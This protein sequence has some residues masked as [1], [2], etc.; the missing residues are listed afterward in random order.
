MSVNK[1]ILALVSISI[2]FIGA[3]LGYQAY[4]SLSGIEDLFDIE[5]DD[6]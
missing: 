2:A 1:K 4:N 5:E 3:Y 6:F